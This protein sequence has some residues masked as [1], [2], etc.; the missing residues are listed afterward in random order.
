SVF[1]AEHCKSKIFKRHP[2]YGGVK[3]IC[4]VQPRRSAQLVACPHLVD[5]SKKYPMEADFADER[6]VQTWVQGLA[7]QDHRVV[8]RANA[9]LTS[10]K[11]SCWTWPA[12][13]MEAGSLG[14]SC[15][16]DGRSSTPAIWDKCAREPSAAFWPSRRTRPHRPAKTIPEYEPP[17]CGERADGPQNPSNPT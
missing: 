6:I 15:A 2:V 13:L 12:C 4:E 10:A 8:Q 14:E 9:A 11:S 1:P 17:L 16:S 7:A 5:Y 3:K